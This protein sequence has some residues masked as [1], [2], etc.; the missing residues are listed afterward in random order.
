MSISVLQMGK[1]RHR[2]VLQ[3]GSAEP[4]VE[5]GQSLSQSLHN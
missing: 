2:K 5:A 1:L 4:E 3:L